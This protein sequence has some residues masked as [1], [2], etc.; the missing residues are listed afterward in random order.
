MLPQGARLRRGFFS[1]LS[2]VRRVLGKW[3]RCWGVLASGLASLNPPGAQGLTEGGAAVLPCGLP[4]EGGGT[5][6]TWREADPLNHL[7]EK[8]DPDQ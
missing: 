3:H 5:V 6:V 2:C 8:V 7:G 4:A 1:R